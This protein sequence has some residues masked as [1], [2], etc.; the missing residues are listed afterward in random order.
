MFDINRKYK[1][2]N[3]TD[4]EEGVALRLESNRIDESVEF[5]K[6]EKI[7]GLSINRVVGYLKNDVSCLKKFNFIKHL[8]IVSRSIEDITPI[9]DLH[10]LETLIVQTECKKEIDFS[11]FP[12]LK[13]ARF[14]WRPRAKSMFDCTT[15][16]EIGIWS[17][18]PKSRDLI[19]LQKLQNLKHAEFISAAIDTLNGVEKLKNLEALELYYMRSLQTIEGV[20]QLPRLKNV[21]LGSCKKVESIEPLRLMT[22]LE[23]LALENMGD[24][25]SL[26]P[27]KTLSKLHTLA[28]YETKIT[29]GNMSHLYQMKQMKKLLY[30]YYKHY[31]DTREQV[32]KKIK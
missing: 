12:K 8:N 4:D 32:L 30:K 22:Q 13:V 6:K 21:R 18:K 24:I 19:D 31:T 16:E 20:E 27:I 26:E 3:V 25:P 10:D 11:C 5:M 23:W 1:G 2:F 15:L 29:D 7:F 9:H 17:F 28:L 14:K